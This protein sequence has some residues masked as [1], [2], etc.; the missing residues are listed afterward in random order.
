VYAARILLGAKEQVLLTSC[1]VIYTKIL[2][3]AMQ[4]AIHYLPLGMR[5]L[6][7]EK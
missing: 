2:E 1:A 3:D 6:I 5:Q 7:C 4:T